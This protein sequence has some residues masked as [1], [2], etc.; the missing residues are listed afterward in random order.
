MEVKEIELVTYRNGCP[1]LAMRRLLVSDEEDLQKECRT[2]SLVVVDLTLS[3]FR[4]GVKVAFD[5]L[6]DRDVIFEP[7]TAFFG[8]AYKYQH[9]L[10]GAL[11]DVITRSQSSPPSQ[12]YK[13][14]VTVADDSF[15]KSHGKFM[16]VLEA[17]ALWKRQSG[18]AAS[19]AAL[20]LSNANIAGDG[21]SC[22]C[23]ELV[24]SHTVPA[25]LDLSHNYINARAMERSIRP[26]LEDPS[27]IWVN[28]TRNY[29]ASVDARL[30]FLTLPPGLLLKVVWINE[31]DLDS[32]WYNV[33]RSEDKF[34]QV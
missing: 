25:V 32:C 6:Q 20:D 15:E 5:E 29:G 11:K 2:R 22:L 30:H 23:Q 8:V 21:F 14:S 9:K 28:L 31:T 4:D 13:P 3:I 18:H 24:S 10:E 19:R 34:R 1:G 16:G 26:L 17:L 33:L 12:F 27:L 7:D